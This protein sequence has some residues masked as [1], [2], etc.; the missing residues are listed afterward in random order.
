MIDERHRGQP[1]I[2]AADL[3]I[4]PDVCPLIVQ[5]G[6]RRVLAA[7]CVQ[8]YEVERRQKFLQ[9]DQLFGTRLLGTCNFESMPCDHIS[10]RLFTLLPAVGRLHIVIVIIAEVV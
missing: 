4:C 2:A 1:Q 5:R 8:T 3:C 9:F 10:H 6:S 7:H